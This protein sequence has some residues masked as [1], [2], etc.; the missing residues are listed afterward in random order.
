VILLPDRDLAIPQRKIVNPYAERVPIRLHPGQYEVFSNLARFRV[1]AAGRRWG[2]STV[3]KTAI[4]DKAQ[5]P[6]QK[7]WYVAPTYRMA[8]QIMWYDMLDT[9]PRRWMRRQPNETTMTLY[10]ANG[11]TI[12]LKGADNPD[13]LRGVGLH[14]IVLDEVQDM[15]EEVWTKVLRPTLATTGGHAIFIGCVKGDTLVLPHGGARTIESYS[16]GSSDKTLDPMNEEFYGLDR[17]FHKADGFWNNGRVETRVIKTAMG[18]EIEA[19]LPHQVWVMSKSGVDGWK[20][21]QDLEV[22]DRIAISRGMEVW[23][24]RDPLEGW[25]AHVKKWRVE[26]KN[27]KPAQGP[28]L[29]GLSVD[30]MNEDLAYFLGLWTAE[31]SFEEK[32]GRVSITCGDSEVGDF[33]MSGKVLDLPFKVRGKSGDVWAVNSMEMLELMRYLGM[34]LVKAPKKRIPA[35]V[36]QGRREWAAAFLAGLV[37]GDGYVSSTRNK[38]GFTSSSKELARGV[39]LLLSNFGI[40]GKL[41]AVDSQPTKLV[42]VV[43]RQ[44]RLEMHG[45]NVSLFKRSIPLRIERKAKLLS[46]MRDDLFSRRDGVPYIL[47]LLGALRREMPRIKATTLKNVTS[48]AKKCGSDSSYRSLRL[49]L[50]ECKEVAHTQ[51]YRALKKLVDDGYYWDE[52]VSL[53]ASESVTYDFTIPETHS[54]WSNGFISH[55]SPKGFNLLYKLWLLGQNE[56]NQRAR[57]W[58]SW[59]FP[60]ITSPFVPL[61]EIEQ[62]RADMDEKSFRQEFMASFESSSGRV[63]YPFDRN[64]H[65]G[66]YPFNPDLPIWVGQDFNINPMSSVILQPQRNGEIWAVSE[67]VRFDSNVV[68]VSD[69]IER[70]YWRY[71]KRVTIYP[72]PAGGNKQHARGESSLDVFREKGFKRIKYRKKHPFVQDRVNSVNR[73]L[74]SADGTVHLRIDKSCKHLITS[75]EQTLY[76]DDGSKEI[77]KEMGIEHS[78]F[79]GDQEVNVNGKR[80]QFRDIPEIG[81]VLCHDGEYRRYV[82]GGKVRDFSQMLLVTLSNGVKIKCTDDHLFLTTEGWLQASEIDGKILC[83]QSLLATLFRNTKGFDT[84]F[85]KGDIF[86]ETGKDFIA[87]CGKIILEKS[88]KGSTFITKMKTSETIISTICNYCSDQNTYRFIMKGENQ[89]L[90]TQC[91]RRRENSMVAKSGEIG[92]NVI[93][94]AQKMCCTAEEIGMSAHSAALNSSAIA[95]NE[96]RFV[97]KNARRQSEEG[98]VSTT[99]Q[100]LASF[101][102]DHLSPTNTRMSKHAVDHA[103]RVLHIKRLEPDSAYCLTVPNFGMFEVGGVIV[104]NCDALG[105]PI[106]FEFPTRKIEVAGLSY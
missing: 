89:S 13:N 73:Q 26:R 22:G 16:I 7:I 94:S 100:E 68:E 84:I 54:F 85:A 97:R 48:T 41:S 15:R 71:H 19:S 93:T 105:Y 58:H 32:I 14:F 49:I 95:S 18:F 1:I 98:M 45:E 91:E 104:S 67:I 62:A 102:L 65:V 11:T 99:R 29:A 3:S 81:W 17:T 59:Q 61:E 21:T 75:L 2:K 106:E 42:K 88:Q 52:I 82:N 76:K 78:C 69:E 50:D 64:V 96:L 28:K 33:L 12:E 34:S 31:G 37:D 72:D 23:G 74:R 25:G 79:H 30:G 86:R 39:Q 63:Y 55:N 46:A 40:I 103:P 80:M 57:R 87:S 24:N 92:T 51:A 10:L 60:T 4:I 56:R 43:S 38:V 27:D 9:I 70:R 47:P 77:D 83:N 101:V 44:Y 8:K 5:I 6:K 53:E 20:T 66:D 35:W 36:W 90:L